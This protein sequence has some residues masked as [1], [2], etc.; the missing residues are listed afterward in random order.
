MLLTLL[1]SAI[2]TGIKTFT[3]E[4]SVQHEPTYEVSVQHEPFIDVFVTTNFDG[5]DL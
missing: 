1:Q 4:V 2:V 3:A 5:Y